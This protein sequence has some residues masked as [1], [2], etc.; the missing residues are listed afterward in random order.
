[1]P[2]SYVR[3]LPYSTSVVVRRLLLILFVISIGWDIDLLFSK[4]L[5]A[6]GMMNPQTWSGVAHFFVAAGEAIAIIGATIL[7]L[8]MLYFCLAYSKS[9]LKR[10]FWTIGFMLTIWWGAQVYYVFV[11]RR[12]EPAGIRAP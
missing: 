5:M 4:T 3:D 6:H 10:L 2:Y 1:M 8:V 12:R 7:W 11:Y 9:N